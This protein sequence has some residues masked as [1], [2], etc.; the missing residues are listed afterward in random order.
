MDWTQSL[1]RSQGGRRMV[2]TR[3]LESGQ[4]KRRINLTRSLERS[5]GEIL[6]RKRK[7]SGLVDTVYMYYAGLADCLVAKQHFR[8]LVCLIKTVSPN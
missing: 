6:T 2:P 8:Q 7:V 3:S 5:Q 4:G 1:E